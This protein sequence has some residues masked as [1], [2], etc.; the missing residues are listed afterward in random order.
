MAGISYLLDTNIAIAILNQESA[1][2]S[3]L[4][5]NTIYIPTIALGELCFGAYKSART[6]ENL[7]RIDQFIAQYELLDVDRLTARHYGEIK[8]ILQQKGRPL[9]ENDIWIAAIAIQYDLPLVTRDAHFNAVDGL[10]VEK[11]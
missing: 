1:I 8:R 10:L 3:H 7:A 4:T 5:G 6:S 9:P 11:W 2:E